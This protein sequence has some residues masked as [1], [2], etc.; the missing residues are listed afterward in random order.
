M[1]IASQSYLLLSLLERPKGEKHYHTTTCK[2]NRNHH[3][4]NCHQELDPDHHHYL[5]PH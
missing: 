1:S 3:C 5:H 2:G 4:H